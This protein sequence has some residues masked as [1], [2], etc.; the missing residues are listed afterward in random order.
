[1]A[2]SKNVHALIK[3]LTV[4]E[5]AYF[6]RFCEE[7]HRTEESDFKYLRLFEVMDELEEFDKKVLQ[8]AFPEEY[9]KRTLHVLVDYLSRQLLKVLRLLNEGAGLIDAEAEIQNMMQEADLMVRR[10]LYAEAMDH[11][12]IAKR[13]ARRYQKP[14]LL[15]SIYV[16]EFEYVVANKTTGFR[17]DIKLLSEELRLALR[18]FDLENRAIVSYYQVGVLF[19]NGE[20]QNDE[21]LEKLI[22]EWDTALGEANDD[23]FTF[24]TKYYAPLIEAINARLKGD[25]PEFLHQMEKVVNIWRENK[26]QIKD[27]TTRFIVFLTNYLSGLL[28]LEQYDKAKKVLDEADQLKCETYDEKG[29][30]FQSI[31]FNRLRYYM[32]KSPD[33]PKEISEEKIKDIE[34]GLREYAKKINF[35]REFAFYVNLALLY[36][37]R[38]NLD[39]AIHWILKIINY[40]KTDHRKDV[41]RFALFL[42]IYFLHDQEQ[43]DIVSK[44]IK[45]LKR[46]LTYKEGVLSEFEEIIFANFN[47]D[48]IYTISNKQKKEAFLKFQEALKNWPD[49]NTIGYRE[50]LYWVQNN[51]R[52]LS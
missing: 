40:K 26:H 35:A 19:R 6:K 14:H 2:A 34:Q 10:G 36:F 46:Q 25:D 30:F 33:S 13:R 43:W 11:L 1:M 22:S 4:N 21:Q 32:D 52:K 15:L 45:N 20:G 12:Q 8:T 48:L 18:Q 51:I 27:Q 23:D 44:M 29:E 28:N 31:E 50:T 41:Q 39:M 5:K 47:D 24:K 49:E 42:R 3:V 7:Q 9:A 17:E 37:F 38:G 16:K